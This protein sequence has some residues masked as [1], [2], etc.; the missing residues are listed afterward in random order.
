MM[1]KVKIRNGL[2]STVM[3]DLQE[4]YALKI[5]ASC[6][7]E[8]LNSITRHDEAKCS[9]DFQ[10]SGFLYILLVSINPLITV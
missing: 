4:M 7:H 5:K 6:C 8:E 2:D 10:I 9:G 1:E 3:I